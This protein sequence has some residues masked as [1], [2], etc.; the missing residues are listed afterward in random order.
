MN[1]IIGSRRSPMLIVILP[2]VIS[3]L[4]V[5][6]GGC[7]GKVRPS[8]VG[9]PE[10][11]D[12]SPDYHLNLEPADLADLKNYLA[13][14]GDRLALENGEEPDPGAL[15]QVQTTYGSLL[16]RLSGPTPI[17]TVD[18]DEGSAFGSLFDPEFTVMSV[19]DARVDLDEEGDF[20]DLVGERVLARI[21]GD[22]VFAF[23]QRRIDGEPVKIPSAPEDALPATVWYLS[24]TTEE[25]LAS[26]PVNYN[27]LV[28]FKKGFAIAGKGH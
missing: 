11:I 4:L 27:G 14:D 9:V 7:C 3:L 6:L 18:F 1:R 2:L 17:T 5:S 19:H 16:D 21:S 24:G 12:R 25:V 22:F 8:F 15:N 26:G 28:V 10:A 20:F 23:Y 13:L